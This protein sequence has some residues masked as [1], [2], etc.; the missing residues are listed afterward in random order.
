MNRTSSRSWEA[1]VPL[2]LT[3]DD[4][5]DYF[6]DNQAQE[7]MKTYWTAKQRGAEANLVRIDAIPEALPPTAHPGEV[8]QIA[9]ERI[10]RHERLL[11]DRGIALPP[12]V[13]AP[14]T[15][16]VP[17]GTDNFR[18]SRQ[19]W[20]DM[21]ETVQGLQ[22]V[23]EAVR[24]E[25]R[26]D[27]VVRV[28]DLRMS[29]DGTLDF[30]EGPVRLEDQGLRALVSRNAEVLPRA[31]ELLARVD[32][33][34]RANILNRQL[35][36][37]GRDKELK[38][39]LRDGRDGRQVFAVVSPRYAP[40]DA[41]RIATTL[42]SALHGSG[43]RGQVLYDARTTTLRADG[44]LHADQPVD[45]AAG[46]VFKL[47]VQFR[48]NDAAGGSIVGKAIAWRNLCLNLIIIGTGEAELLRRRHIGAVGEVLS[49]VRTA[50]TQASEMFVDFASEWGVLRGTDATELFE[51]ASVEDAIAELVGMKELDVGVR[52][53]ALVEM[54]LT[55]WRHEPGDSVAD[56]V[57][58]VTAVHLLEDI[59]DWQRQRFE[60]AAGALVPILA[61]RA[62]E[63]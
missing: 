34:L 14:G 32:P 26:E 36:Q 4:N 43:M 51:V 52:R 57:N 37:V 15:K 40:F 10:E 28:R 48:S 23:Y 61:R 11:A 30:G 56:L 27:H 60:E 25:N 63:A 19:S 49:D 17:L 31:G 42:A 53:D 20:E 2:A 9:Q 22:G 44:L 46:D 16:V 7:A 50:A 59:D 3:I 39:R 8:S 58:S 6:D 45:L 38:L 35:G 1:H 12:P 21:P 47:G 24:A 29:E 18:T 62:A 33:E 41:D 55:G 13:Y 54:L 5:T